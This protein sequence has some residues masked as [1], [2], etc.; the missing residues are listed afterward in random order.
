MYTKL[1]LSHWL[2]LR[3]LY[4]PNEFKLKGKVMNKKLLT[5]LMLVMLLPMASIAYAEEWSEFFD[6][7][8]ADK[9]LSNSIQK[10]EKRLPTR[11]QIVKRLDQEI[12][13]L[14]AEMSQKHGDRKQVKRYLEQ[15]NRQ[16][17]HSSFDARVDNLRHY[18][19][20]TSSSSIEVQHFGYAQQIR[21]PMHDR[22]A[23]VAIVLPISGRYGTAG[24]VLQNTLQSSLKK[25]GFTGKLI[26][27]DSGIYDSVFEMW[28]ILKYYDPDFIF[29]PLEKDKVLAWQQ[30]RTEVPTL[31]FNELAMHGVGEY[32]LSPSK[33]SGL[34]QVFQ[35]L[36]QAQY[37]K[38]LVLKDSSKVSQ[39]LETSFHQSWSAIN[40]A[41]NY[42]SQPIE[43]NVGKAID[44]GLNVQASKDRHRWLQQVINQK[45]EF[46]P[47]ARHDI[48]AVISFVPQNLAIQVAPYLHFLPLDSAITHVWYPSKTPNLNYLKANLDAWQQ[49]FA[50]LPLLIPTN[51]TKNHHQSIP[52]QKTGL[53]HALGQVAIEIVKNSAMASTIDNLVETPSGTYVGNASGQFHLLPVVYWADNGVIEKYFILTE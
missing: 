17:I 33:L 21:F 23:V 5:L 32:S 51:L 47:R 35:V 13:I 53:F 6:D 45:T 36:Q 8:P 30:L 41:D 49:T 19:A 28:E 39:D 37:Q 38:I 40:Q 24:E 10:S 2:R 15:L 1:F 43:K 42:V 7:Y 16:K 48:E 22:N 20:T 34:E 29:G 52:D 9:R 11:L 4:L 44:E 26:A 31:Y 50:I 18:M 46:S 14:R 27:L 25:E 3:N 12:L